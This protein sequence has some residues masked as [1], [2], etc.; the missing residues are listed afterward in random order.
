MSFKK[1]IEKRIFKINPNKHNWKIE[2]EKT[3]EFYSVAYI[4]NNTERILC[5]A[6][7]KRDLSLIYEYLVQ[8]MVAL[9]IIKV[10]CELKKKN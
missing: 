5:F 10:I 1:N 9:K 7:D 2:K 4:K 3:S 6:G 8:Q